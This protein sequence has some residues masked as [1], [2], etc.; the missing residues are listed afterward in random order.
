MKNH[1]NVTAYAIGWINCPECFEQ[2]HCV[3][4]RGYPSNP[5]RD[6]LVK[7]KGRFI[8]RDMLCPK[9]GGWYKVTSAEFQT[10]SWSYCP[11]GNLMVVGEEVV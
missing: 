2:I 11:V 4:T 1:S 9:C 6:V 5:I 10:K 7:F 8:G 3:K